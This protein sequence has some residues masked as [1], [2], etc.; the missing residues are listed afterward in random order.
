MRPGWTTP[1]EFIL[2]EGMLDS[3]I[4]LSGQLVEMKQIVLKGSL[5]VGVERQVAAN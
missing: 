5:E 4:R 1:A 3:M 2:V